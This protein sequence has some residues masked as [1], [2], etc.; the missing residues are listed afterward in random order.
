MRSF[1]RDDFGK[2]RKFLN[3]LVEEGAYIA[4]DRPLSNSEE[5]EMDEQ[6]LARMNN[7]EMILWVVE[8]GGKIIGRVSAERMQ[9][10]ERDN[11]SLSFYISS[12]FRGAGLGTVLIRM[13]VKESVKVFAPHNLYLTVYSDNSKAIALYEREGFE[14]LGV[15]PDWMRNNDTYMDR[16]YMVYRHK[17]Q[18]AKG[19]KGEPKE[20]KKGK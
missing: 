2:L 10:R 11:V 7:R 18:K 1:T 12:E 4:I 16:V 17:G 6:S 13:I 15:L 5:R 9:R 14:K 8:S 3:G 19:G 20:R